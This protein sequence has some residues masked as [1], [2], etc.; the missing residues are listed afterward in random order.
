MALFVQGLVLGFSAAAQPGP[1]QAYLLAQSVRNGAGRT[2]PVTMVPLVSDPLVI[3]VVLAAL[4]QV[5][6]GFLRVLQVMGGGILLWLGAGAL[7]AARSARTRGAD[8]GDLRRPRG[9]WRAVFLNL[10]NPSVW[11]AWSVVMGP[12][13][14]AAWRASP[15]R[16]LAFVAGFY[17]FLVGGNLLLVLLAARV[18]GLGPGFARGLGAASGIALVVLGLWHVGRG[19][20]GA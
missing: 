20:A 18:S 13:V 10:T 3:A 4:A 7:R 11:I 17:L 8:S 14:S 5:P 12:V 16:A 1:L 2:F 15:A 9:F 19:V 6:A